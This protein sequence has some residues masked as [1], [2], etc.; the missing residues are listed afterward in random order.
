MKFDI[1]TPILSTGG[2]ITAIVNFLQGELIYNII[3]IIV[4]IT[5]IVLNVVKI[6]R[7]IKPK[8]DA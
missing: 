3:G 6:Y 1:E 7:L 2:I 5:V 4:S 8:K